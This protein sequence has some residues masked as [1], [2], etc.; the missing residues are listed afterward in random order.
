MVISLQNGYTEEMKKNKFL[1]VLISLIILY[2]NI[3]TV[4]AQEQILP[5]GIRESEL[6]EI[7]NKYVEDNKKTTA[8]MAY[9]VFNG[10]K[11]IAFG[12]YGYVDKEN[13]IKV[14]KDTVFEWGSVS[15]VMVW[16]SVMQLAEQ[17]KINLQADI[18]EYLPRDVLKNLN[19][20]NNITMIHLMNHSAGFQESYTD[21]F[22]KDAEAYLN[23]EEAI[24]EH[25]PEQIF[26]PGTVVAYSNWST[27]L[28]AYIVEQV[29][30]LD[31]VQY[32][33]TNIFE[34]LGMEHS[35]IAMDLSDNK[36]VAEK[37]KELMSYDIAG[38]KIEDVFYYI[39]LY[40][41][42]MCTSTLEDFEVFAKSLMDE[43]TVLFSDSNTW[44][45]MF[46][47]TDYYS[48]TEIARNYHGMWMIPLGV[49]TIGH[50]GNTAGCSSYLLMNLES[51]IGIVVMTNQAN[52]S[53]YNV[54]MMEL[55]YG[56]YTD[57][58][59]VI[60]KG[61]PQGIYKSAR[62]FKV[63][64]LKILNLSYQG[65][66]NE[67][68]V[69]FTY[70]TEGPLSKIEY[71]YVDGY[72]ITFSE[73]FIELSIVGI[74]ILTF[75][76]SLIIMIVRGIRRINNKLKKVL[77]EK[78]IPYINAT[79]ATELLIMAFLT[80]GYIRILNYELAVT[81]QWSFAVV[82]ILTVILCFVTV[83]GCYKTITIKE[84]KKRYKA[85]NIILIINSFSMIVNI[86]FWNLF[87]F[88]AL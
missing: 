71:P 34:P 63:G 42:G 40:P 88:W 20:D 78:E 19:Y 58:K 36:W 15:K 5:S 55:I 49:Q 44:K 12:Y 24:L 72:E 62:T 87:M 52:E 17:G 26:E 38:N 75:M 82:G 46:T 23:L 13:N 11:E 60:D 48:G 18:R 4:Y 30:G 53:V 16:V 81:Y 2:S 57:E 51:G 85:E 31:Y 21:I 32:V 74:F 6:E 8:G 86:C 29:S 33:H 10:E 14:D 54:E 76:I 43:N 37:R 27:A 73:M 80:Y 39:P 35:A 66:L 84:Q 59:Y 65:D 28:A 50:G 70:N 68:D 7:I 45:E 22:V 64:P 79:F 69:F 83:L 9:A 56:E 41:V 67:E 47:P 3:G 61:N 77:K 1:I 25:Q